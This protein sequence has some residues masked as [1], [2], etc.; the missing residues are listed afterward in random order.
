MKHDTEVDRHQ[1]EVDQRQVQHEGGIALGVTDIE[2]EGDRRREGEHRDAV[3]DPERGPLGILG[4]GDMECHMPQRGA[5]D[6][7]R[8]AD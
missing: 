4:L 6:P 3:E 8:R 1:H 7:Q 5:Q 2:I